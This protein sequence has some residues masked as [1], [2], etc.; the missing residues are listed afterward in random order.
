VTQAGFK[1]TRTKP[2]MFWEWAM[3]A[4]IYGIE[5]SFLE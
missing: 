5:E 3:F 4:K 2:K 1:R